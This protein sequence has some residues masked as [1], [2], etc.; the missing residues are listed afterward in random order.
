[1]ET[2]PKLPS[3]S[4]E[5]R[6]IAEKMRRDKLNNYVS[7][8]ASI[9]PLVG[10]STKRVDKTSILRLA[11]NYIRMHNILGDS[12][13]KKVTST[14]S[15]VQRGIM[16]SL[17]EAIGGFLLVVT[18]SGKVVFI[19]EAVESFFG[20][21]QVDLL[22]SCLFNVIHTE[23]HDIL[24]EQ[25]YSKEDPRR[26]FFCRMMEKTLSRNDPSRY[27][28][29]HIVGTL[30]PLLDSCSS[31]A[32]QN[33]S[34]TNQEQTIEPAEST[35]SDLDE[36]DAQKPE[37]NRIGT[38]IL[39]GFVRIVKDRPITELFLTESNHDEYIT[40][41]TMDGKIL[42]TDHRISFVTGLMPSEVLGTSAFKYMHSED[43]VWSMVA[44]KLMFTSSQ[45]QGVVS[46]RL[47]CKGGSLVT[48]RSRGYIELNKTTGQAETFVC[49]NTV[50]SNN[51]A[52]EEMKNQRRKLLPII[53]NEEGKDHLGSVPSSMPPEFL[54][55]LKLIMDS[56]TIQKIISEVDKSFNQNSKS[57]PSKHSTKLEVCQEYSTTELLPQRTVKNC[58]DAD[59][60]D[61]S[62]TENSPGYLCEKNESQAL[63]VFRKRNANEELCTL[64]AKI[65]TNSS[66]LCKAISD[67]HR[68]H[69]FS[70]LPHL[71][72][73]TIQPM[74]CTPST[75]TEE[76]LENRTNNHSSPSQFHTTDQ[77][78]PV[79]TNVHSHN[80]PKHEGNGFKYHPP[81]SGYR[82]VHHF[83]EC[84]QDYKH[85]FKK[86]FDDNDLHVCHGKMSNS[87]SLFNK[88]TDCQLE[89]E[90]RFSQNTSTSVLHSN[91]PSHSWMNPQYVGSTN[92]LS[93]NFQMP[94]VQHTLYSQR[95]TGPY[96]DTNY[97]PS[98]PEFD[99]K[100]QRQQYPLDHN[101]HWSQENRCPSQQRMH[102]QQA[103][104]STSTF[105]SLAPVVEPDLKPAG[106]ETLPN[107]PTQ[108]TTFFGDNQGQ[109]P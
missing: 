44:H 3:S 54:S 24:K 40:R 91:Y 41:H 56:K 79:V 67:A 75:L 28:I 60:L 42:Y 76:K 11:A 103:W 71:S 15:I 87:Y 21:T 64:P 84:Y 5:M 9:I 53:A 106:V 26:S 89:R 33:M 109:M 74:L 50:V 29:I 104:L 20:Y 58:K 63:N 45:G 107:I 73:D 31:T 51:E 13:E 66:Y 78:D 37:S 10:G 4:R 16:T 62:Q 14:K 105:S 68:P 97:C 61:P 22:G 38:H 49:I 52:E 102:P 34:K 83:Q 90:T 86:D 1:M 19:T 32:M 59:L 81:M 17:E 80:Y 23:D 18:S 46:Y 55:M 39:V 6:N 77:G 57:H 101:P 43:M 93:R 99:I 100:L 72:H 88:S 65:P 96:Q 7:E 82:D 70:P 35:C 2:K 69:T 47:K 98:V 85:P 25:L 94:A 92:G 8:L 108:C 27:E 30:K 95:F 36:D 48:L 12:V